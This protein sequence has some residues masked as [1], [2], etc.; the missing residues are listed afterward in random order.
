MKTGKRNILSIFWLAFLLAAST[1]DLRAQMTAAD[2]AG[3]NLEMMQQVSFNI[4]TLVEGLSSH[5]LK[6]KG[7]FISEMDHGMVGY[8][9]KN[10]Q[11]MNAD[12]EYIIVRPNGTAYYV[13]VITGEEA[14]LRLYFLAFNYGAANYDFDDS[15][16]KLTAKPDAAL[17]TDEKDVY[18]LMYDTTQ[19]GT[20]TREKKNRRATIIIGYVK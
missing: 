17:S 5:F 11:H 10:L 7:D 6:F 1:S 19:V 4:G 9:V 2:S 15:E 12:H 18:A 3:T 8:K 20:F 14:R 13:A 16:V